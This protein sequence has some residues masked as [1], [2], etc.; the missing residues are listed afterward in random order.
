MYK[1]HSVLICD[2][3]SKNNDNSRTERRNRERDP[4]L[5]LSW[6]VWVYYSCE[7]RCDGDQGAEPCVYLRKHGPGRGG[8]LHKSLKA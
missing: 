8:S 7:W 6:V 5:S 1:S 3:C 2:K 4:L